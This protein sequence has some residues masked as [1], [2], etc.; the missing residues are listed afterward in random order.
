MTVVAS[1]RECSCAT[2]AKRSSHLVVLLEISLQLKTYIQKYVMPAYKNTYTHNGTHDFPF[3]LMHLSCNMQKELAVSV[4]N[5]PKT[6]NP[7]A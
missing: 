6:L 3:L 7:E 1:S 4:W 5:P 2:K